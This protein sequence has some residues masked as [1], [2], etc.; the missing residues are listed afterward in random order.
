M[1][2]YLKTFLLVLLLS[3][4]AYG[5]HSWLIVDPALSLEKTYIFLGVATFITVSGLKFTHNYVPDKL[6]FGFL[7]LVF[8]K[9]GAALLIFPDLLNEDP[10]LTQAEMLGF[11]TPYFIFLFIEVTIVIKWLNDN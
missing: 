6:G 10:A 3:L 5:V 4:V 1:N 9:C 8:V 2:F 11:L 7:A